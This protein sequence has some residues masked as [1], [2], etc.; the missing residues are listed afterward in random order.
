MGLLPAICLLLFN[1]AV[2][3]VRNPN[4]ADQIWAQCRD[5]ENLE[6]SIS[7]CSAI[8]QSERQTTDIL[9]QAFYSRGTHYRHKGLY[10]QAISDFDE[11]IKLHPSA[12]ALGNRGFTY[13]D[14][15]Q[16]DRAIADFND[17]ISLNPNTS[18]LRRGR[19][20]AYFG[21]RQ[22][23]NAIA[24]Y[25]KAIALNE[26]D[27]FTPNVRVKRDT[28][29]PFIRGIS[30][31]FLGQ[32]SDAEADLVQAIKLNPEDMFRPFWLYLARARAGNDN[33][34]TFHVN[35]GLDTDKWP[36]PLIQLYLGQ[37]TPERVEEAAALG[38]VKTQQQQTC[39]ADFLIGDLYSLHGNGVA[40]RSSLQHAVNVCS[41][42]SLEYLL[43]T[44]ELE[45]LG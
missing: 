43:S 27:V 45:R 16:F 14:I 2:A 19:G 24:D 6:L 29:A 35:T 18:I 7:A 38:D 13:T 22:F 32:F 8:I 36:N 1:T 31:Y 40:A 21:K 44:I 17:A 25:D 39:T 9:S 34:T 3:Q 12:G 33:S 20:N 23:E 42:D 37:T 4:R 26:K 5:G 30:R 10:D 15:G 11:S 41:R 28:F